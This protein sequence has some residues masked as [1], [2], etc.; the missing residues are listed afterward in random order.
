M[1]ALF[2]G[3]VHL[4]CTRDGR[5]LGIRTPLNGRIEFSEV[6]F[7]YP[8]AACRRSTASR[9]LP[10]AGP[11]W[12]LWDATAP[13]KL[14]VTRLVERLHGNYE[15]L[16]KI[17]GTDLRESTSSFALQPR[18]G[19]AGQFSVQRHD[20]RPD[21]RDKAG[22]EL[23]RHRFCC[24]AGGAEEFIE[25]L[26]R[27]YETFVQEGSANLSGGQ[28]QRLAIARALIGDPRS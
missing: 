19:A 26:P 15:G 23:R 17:D 3:V 25:H 20:P 14:T 28:R 11:F 12:A 24:P 2:D 1:P 16:I 4:P 5:R 18:G 7:S 21:R 13:G 10:E 8:A 22:C 27:G 9:L 6:R